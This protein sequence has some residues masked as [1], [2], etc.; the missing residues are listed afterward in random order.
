MH[1]LIPADRYQQP[2]NDSKNGI[3]NLKDAEDIVIN[4][5][6]INYVPKFS[7][8]M[9]VHNEQDSISN[10]VL[11]VYGKLGENPNFPFEIILSEDGSK[12]NTK[13]VILNLSKKIPLKATLSHL[14]RG[15]AGGI[16]HG[17]EHVSSPFVLISDSDGQHRPED[18]WKLKNKLDELE[19]PKDWIVSGNRTTRADDLHRKIISKTFQ[20]LNSIMFD[21]PPIKDITSPFK[22]IE[23]NLAK[24]LASECKYM[25]ESFWTEFIVRACRKNINIAEV[26]VQ[27]VNRLEGETTVYKKSKIP[28]IVLKQ[29]KGVFDIKREFTGKGL[30]SSVILHT[31][32]IKQLLSYAVVG[33][34]GAGII[35]FLTWL[36]VDVFG[37]N[38]LLSAAIAIELSIVWAFFLNDR[39]TFK[40]KIIQF[41]NQNA[42]LSRLK[43]LLKYN[44]SSLSGE[45]IN[46]SILYSLT[47]LGLFYLHSE[48][49]AI[50][51][52]FSY[53]F[54]I[55]NKWVWAIKRQSK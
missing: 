20:K 48:A 49:I 47:S 31:R 19:D 33:A 7:I 43:R 46:L 8:L 10:V 42:S 22:L 11:D 24:N 21:L 55:S 38:Y 14:K 36:F 51:V 40:H 27:H 52:A 50:L 25:N 29:L 23:S 39:F 4:T 1:E 44:L 6:P 18:F 30:L 17:L 32:S 45:A 12:D 13:E 54:T 53:N 16:K 41:Q 3:Q 9:P 28:K 2:E 15:Y 26:Q 35:L 5:Y 37:L 34:S